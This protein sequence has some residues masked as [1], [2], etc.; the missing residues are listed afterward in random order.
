MENTFLGEEQQSIKEFENKKSNKC[1]KIEEI[2]EKISEKDKEIKSYEDRLNKKRSEISN[3]YIKIKIEDIKVSSFKFPKVPLSSEEQDSLKQLQNDVPNLKEAINKFNTLNKIDF[4]KIDLIEESKKIENDIFKFDREKLAINVS[5][6]IKDHLNKVGADFIE[7]GIKFTKDDNKFCPFCRQKIDNGILDEYAKY[8][9]KELQ[10]FSQNSEKFSRDIDNEI[11][12]IQNNKANILHTFKNFHAF[13][14]DFDEK[15][16]DLDINLNLLIDILKNIKKLVDK[17]IGIKNLD[18]YKENIENLKEKYNKCTKI[19]GE[20]DKILDNRKIQEKKFNNSKNKW[21]ELTIKQTKFQTYEDQKNQ[22]D[23]ENR[24]K[25]FEDEV[26]K[27]ISEI[28][29]LENDIKIE[30][31]KIK[32]DIKVINAYLKSLNLSKYTINSDYQLVLNKVDIKNKNANIILSDGEKTTLAFAY[33]LAK[34]KMNYDKNSLRDL[35]IVIDD[36]ISSLDENRI[37]TTSYLVAKINQEIA[38]ENL[39][40]NSEDKAQIFVLTHNG[41]FMSNLIRIIGRHSNY[42][43]LNRNKYTLKFEYKN[44]AAGYFD[45]FYTNLFKE[46][47]NFS[48]EENL[49]DDDEDKALNYGNK[50]RILFESFMKVNFISKFVKNEYKYQNVFNSEV[51]KEITKKIRECNKDY[52][53]YSDVFKNKINNDSSCVIENEDGLYK[54]LDRVVKGLHMDSH[55]SVA[56]FYYNHKIS[57]KEVQVFAKIIINVMISLN[58]HQTYFY[59][60]ACN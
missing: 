2:N 32:P 13:I 22:N 19:I 34:L 45:T 51:M 8:F 41:I 5:Q 7:H 30:Q 54:K 42:Y 35:V 15:K 25:S 10:N 49:N 17:K 60:E 18:I 56:N 23:L 12:K 43:I 21:K 38:S 31:E 28:K 4:F 29:K 58:P 3:E 33:F 36:P 53:F 50:I 20:T 14:E 27:L 16:D 39:V 26:K 24:K 9:N 48:M 47:Y 37:Y 55:G 40:N 46:I 52:N 59:L 6:N 1:K 11:S 44:N 57:L